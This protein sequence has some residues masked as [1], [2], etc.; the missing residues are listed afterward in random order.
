M[1]MIVSLLLTGCGENKKGSDNQ[2]TTSSR[3]T[4][5]LKMSQDDKTTEPTTTNGTE[6]ST[7]KTTEKTTKKST[8]KTTTT[9]KKTNSTTTAKKVN[10]NII[11]C[12]EVNNYK[13]KDDFAGFV[14]GTDN[15]KDKF[16]NKFS[17]DNWFYYDEKKLYYEGGN[18]DN[19]ILY[20]YTIVSSNND[21][22][23]IKIVGADR[24]DKDTGKVSCEHS[25]IDDEYTY[26]WK[27]DNTLYDSNNKRTLKRVACNK[28]LPKAHP[29]PQC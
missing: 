14:I 8:K 4:T 21:S 17:K 3:T 2:A 13:E 25:H 23:K 9:V 24:Y 1:L 5:T 7:E 27:D 12:W 26:T 20:H 18:F 11:G 28:F 10:R 15:V 22:V 19:G 6:K 16:P 29:S